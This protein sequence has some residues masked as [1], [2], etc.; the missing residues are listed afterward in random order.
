MDPVPNPAPAP[1]P[2]PQPASN[3]D[4]G[5]RENFARVVEAKNNLESQVKTLQGQIQ[6]L[7]EKAATVDLLSAQ[8]NEWKGKASEAE[9]K[10]ATYTELSGVLGT[11]DAEVVGLFDQ[12]YRALPE[13]DRPDRK[14]WIEG[15]RAKPDDAPALLRPWLTPTTP[16]QPNPPKPTPPKPTPPKVPGT[17]ATPPGAPSSVSADEIARVRE[18][19]VKSGDWT[20]WN[21]LKKSMG[22]GK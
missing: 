7:Q 18:A 8:V 6:T 2:A 9:G 19:C 13:K 3:P 5:L 4:T 22:Y 20:K 15:I 16:A 10:F 11:T 1:A 21:E 12:K 17:P 14:A